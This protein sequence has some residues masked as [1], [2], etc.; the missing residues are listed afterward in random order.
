[1]REFVVEHNNYLPQDFSDTYKKFQVTEGSIAIALT[2][3][4]ISTGLKVAIVP[5]EY[6]GA[7]LNQRVAAIEVDS[8]IVLRQFLF[9]FLCT[10]TVIKYV[11]KQANTLMQPNLSITDLKN[12]SV[13]FPP[14]SEQQ[15]LVRKIDTLS[16]ETQ[17]LETIYQQKLKALTELKQSILHKAFAGELTTVPEK[18]I[19]E[20]SA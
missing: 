16:I 6:D 13:P 8:T 12:L 10:K 9:S 19:Q 5:K 3:S 11:K 4:I 18:E 20:A 17:H 14:I 7:L 1:V 15:Q 2:R